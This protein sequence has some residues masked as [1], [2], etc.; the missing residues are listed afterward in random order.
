MC[1]FDEKFKIYIVSAMP[2]NEAA[3]L[4]HKLKG[5]NN[6]EKGAKLKGTKIKEKRESL[7]F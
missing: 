5:A 2:A 1:N 4:G 3:V 6:I 7:K